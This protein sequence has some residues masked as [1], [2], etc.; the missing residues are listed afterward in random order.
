MI[1]AFKKSLDECMNT[2]NQ[3]KTLSDGIVSFSRNILNGAKEYLI[4]MAQ[5]QSYSSIMETNHE[6]FKKIKEKNY[7]WKDNF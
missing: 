3:K 5:I 2:L 1:V 6:D 7:F 4:E